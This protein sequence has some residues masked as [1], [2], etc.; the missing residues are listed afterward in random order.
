MLHLSKY[1][2]WQVKNSEKISEDPHLLTP[3]IIHHTRLK[4]RKEHVFTFFIQL[5]FVLQ[6]FIPCFTGLFILYQVKL[7]GLDS[8]FF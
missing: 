8:S 5:Q 4:L 2:H 1:F 7:D 6:L 3:I